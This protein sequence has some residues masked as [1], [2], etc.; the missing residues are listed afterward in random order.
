VQGEFERWLLQ[1]FIE[2][3]SDSDAMTW[4]SPIWV[5]YGRESRLRPRTIGF[6]LSWDYGEN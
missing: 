4:A 3:L 6:Q 2:N 1:F 5:P